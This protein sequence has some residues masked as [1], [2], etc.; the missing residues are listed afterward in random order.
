M[1]FKMKTKITKKTILKVVIGRAF[2]FKVNTELGQWE[3]KTTISP[4]L[5]PG[6]REKL[7][8]NFKAAIQIPTVSF[9]ESSQNITA[10]QEFDLLLRRVFPKVFSSSLVRHELVGNY[11]H[12][13][14]VAGSDADLEP[15]MLLAH[16]DVVPANEADGWDAPPFSAQELNG[17]IYGRGTIDNKQSVMGVLQ[18]LEYLLER[19]YTPRRSFYIGLGHDEEI[20]GPQGA[21][22]IVDLLSSRGV[23]LLY[24]LDEGLT[25]VDGVVDGLNGPAA[26]LEKNRLPNRF[27]HGPE[28]ATFEHLAH[29]FGWPYRMVMSNLWLFSSLLSSVLEGQPDT[30]AFIRTT[31]AVTMF[32]SGVKINVM[33]AY[34]EAFV[35]FRIHSSQTLKEVLKQIGSIISD[36]RVEVEFVSGFDPLPISS[37]EEDTFGY[38]ILKKTV[39][40]VFSEVTVAPGICVAN[41]DSRHYTKLSHDIYRF[42]PSWYGPGDSARFH[43]VNERISI[44]NYE[45]IVLFYFQLIQN[46]DVRSLTTHLRLWKYLKVLLFSVIFLIALL[47]L[48]ATVRTFT[49]DADLGLQLGQWE[50]TTTLSLHLNPQRRKNQLENFKAAIRIPT[51]S[52]TETNVNTSALNEFD[53]LLRSGSDADLEPYMLLA[54]IDVVPANE[55]D[56]W[57]AP[58][59][60]AQELNGFI[61]GRGTIDNK[62]SVMGILQALEYLLEKGYTPRRSFYIGLG[63]DEEVNG[64][65]GAVNI[66]KLLKSRGVKLLYVLDEGLAVLD[67]IISGLDGPAALIGIS[68]KGQVTV[69]L[70]VITTPG[71]SSMP[72]R[73][74][75]IGILA[76][77]ENPMPRLFGDGPERGTFEHLA[78]KIH[79][80]KSVAL[81]STPQQ[82]NVMPSNAEA[83]VNFRIHSAQTLQEV[84]NLVRWTI[85]DERVTVKMINGF[86]PL[87]VSSYDEQSFGFQII[88]KTVQGMFPQLTVAP[89]ICVGNTD[90]RHYKDI[91]RDI[92][93]FAPSWFKPGDPQRFHGVN[94]RISIKNY[95]EIVLFYFLLI[96]RNDNRKLPDPHVSQHEL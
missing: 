47:F 41:T 45:E 38:Q 35:N 92:Y 49:F 21:V 61:Y 9:S 69:K 53:V 31:T 60:S 28:R 75:S 17:F 73:E 79:H 74:S 80:V 82:M 58:P 67:G 37:Y 19:G 68:E 81:L 55:A 78:H 34:A 42:A 26:L 40:D 29:K 59:F 50:N 44:K 24:V 10:L 18:A 15:Y 39:L 77:A 1:F 48:V 65:H 7:L 57:D 64:L 8:D 84:L 43:G 5:T 87:P 6:E 88:K 46:C 52:F 85:S 71:H 23:R 89:G 20:S 4:D 95:E 33:P 90:S 13:F 56:G 76:S 16:I 22:K 2:T 30:N 12:L 54:H 66:V 36:K 32:N 63:H 96:Q 93:R 3:N 11:S 86:D 94:E 72:P 70:S 51:V 25:I 83:Y 27:G 14:T 62:Q 91:T